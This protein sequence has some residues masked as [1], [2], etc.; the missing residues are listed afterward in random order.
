M[1]ERD[2]QDAGEQ[3]KRRRAEQMPRDDEGQFVARDEDR[4]DDEQVGAARRK[5]DTPSD[6]RLDSVIG[7]AQHLVH[8]A[9]RG[10]VRALLI[11]EAG[12][13]RAIVAGQFLAHVGGDGLLELRLH[14]DLPEPLPFG[15]LLLGDPTETDT[16]LSGAPVAVVFDEPLGREER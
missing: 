12:R 8:L 7:A 14:L 3:R 6:A 15:A 13:E 1:A 11:D 16:V 2:T 9:G 10:R 4:A 5:T